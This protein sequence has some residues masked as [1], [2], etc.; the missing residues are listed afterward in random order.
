MDIAGNDLGVWQPSVGVCDLSAGPSH[1]VCCLMLFCAGRLTWLEEVGVQGG[2]D[3]HDEGERR[4]VLLADI[5]EELRVAAVVKGR[6]ID[7][8]VQ[9]EDLWPRWVLRT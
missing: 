9:V 4:T 7:A 3:S 6:L 1:G 5:Q 8:G 2:V